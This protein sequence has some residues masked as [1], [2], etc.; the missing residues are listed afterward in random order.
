[1]T[2]S[3]A[4]I[5]FPGM[6]ILG[7]FT[8]PLVSLAKTFRDRQKVKSLA[9]FDERMLEDIGLTRDDVMSALAEPIHHRPSWVLV[10][11]VRHAG[12]LS[13]PAPHMTEP[14]LRRS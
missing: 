11:C 6:N 5:T 3:A 14:G 2:R 10:R 1:M 12:T 4:S 7:W 9:E 13:E 8:H